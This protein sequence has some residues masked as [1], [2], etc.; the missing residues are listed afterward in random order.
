MSRRGNLQGIR[1]DRR[2][3]RLG[4]AGALLTF[5]V[6]GVLRVFTV[7]PFHPSDEM[8]HIGYALEVSH[9]RL[10]TIDTPIPGAQ[11]PALQHR[12]NNSKPPNRTIWTANHPPLYYVLT[13]MPLRVGVET[14]HPLGGV[15]AARL[16]TLALSLVGVGLVAVLARQL[17]PGRP[18]IAV[19]AAGLAALVPGL[20]QSSA[21]VYNDALVFATASAALVLT[22]LVVR[23]GLS[24][25]RLAGLA[26]LAAAA[27]LTRATGLLVVGVAA[28]GAL[29]A[30]WLHDRR[31]ARTRA[32]LGVGAAGV[33]VLVAAAVSGWF[34]LRNRS[35]YGSVTGTSALLE[36]FQRGSRG[37]IVEALLTPK[38][39]TGQLQ[40]LWDDSA[41]PSGR[42]GTTVFW[43]LTAVP[44]LG[45]ALGGLRWLRHR[46]APDR[47]MVLAWLLCA[48]LAVLVEL[49][50]ASFYSVG[51]S[52]H[53][54]YVL[55]GLAVLAVLGAV[56]L[57]FLPGGRHALPSV[58]MLLAL[59]VANVV[60]WQRY[61]QLTLQPAPGRSAIGTGL[62]SA[63]LPG[64]MLLPA[65]LVL[66]AGLV[67]Q[68]WALRVLVARPKPAEHTALIELGEPEPAAV[69]E[70][71][72]VA[73]AGA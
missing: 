27:A 33:V 19:A 53:G 47:R 64:W 28:L 59:A 36:K 13:A 9:G 22:A 62:A 70:A 8:S 63:H 35:L 11:I 66:C 41:G 17:V 31:S 12:L 30:V 7:Y 21:A 23:R 51:G 38:F 45:L 29:A 61:L 25:R 71:Q 57:A 56:G 67:A 37:S 16:L 48:G 49:S 58:A 42:N 20:L 18:D 24:W 15:R 39:W 5:A 65:G 10:P 46:V 54:R 1:P 2:A 73:Y 6:L 44:L 3:V 34:Y 26:A 14:G 68:V 60:A 55:P 32:I 4:V 43:Y 40:R 52:A 72:Q 69:V 50:I